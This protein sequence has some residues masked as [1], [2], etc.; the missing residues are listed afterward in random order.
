GRAKRISMVFFGELNC[1]LGNQSRIE[2]LQGHGLTNAIGN[3]G[4][5]DAYVATLNKFGH[6]LENIVEQV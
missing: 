6:D 4:I 1:V 2:Y 3:L 5:T